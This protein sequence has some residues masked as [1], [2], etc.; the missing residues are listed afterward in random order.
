MQPKTL[1]SIGRQDLAEAL[2]S[3]VEDINGRTVEIDESIFVKRWLPLLTSPDRPDLSGWIEL[4]GGGFQGGQFRSVNVTKNGRLL[5]VVP[6]LYAKAKT[7]I[8]YLEE[9][10]IGQI[11]DTIESKSRRLNRSKDELIPMMLTPILSHSQT[12]PEQDAQWLAILKRYGIKPKISAVGSAPAAQ[13]GITTDDD[14]FES[15]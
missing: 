11:M 15:F 6:P 12:N 4:A 9:N 10:S 7:Q 13:Q 8:R 5:F 1:A 14:N 3:L 2:D